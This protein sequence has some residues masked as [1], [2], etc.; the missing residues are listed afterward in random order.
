VK[1]RKAD[2]LDESGKSES[3]AGPGSQSNSVEE[4]GQN[5]MEVPDNGT[6]VRTKAG[7]QNHKRS[8]P[9]LT[10]KAEKKRRSKRKGKR[11]KNKSAGLDGNMDSRSDS[12]DG[13]NSDDPSEDGLKGG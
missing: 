9:S 6:A 11:N 12:S 3:D 4:G 2:V 10:L 5:A 13:D 7:N 1:K 8:K